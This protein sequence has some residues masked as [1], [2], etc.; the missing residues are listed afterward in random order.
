[1]SITTFID[2]IIRSLISHIQHFYSS[3]LYIVEYPTYGRFNLILWH[4]QNFIKQTVVDCNLRNNVA[5][6]LILIDKNICGSEN[7]APKSTLY[8]GL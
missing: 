5:A 6:V 8:A 7:H 4:P 1:V 2:V 3:D